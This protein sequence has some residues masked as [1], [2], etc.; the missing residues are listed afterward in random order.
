MRVDQK[1]ITEKRD[2]VQLRKIYT[3][4]QEM[5]IHSEVC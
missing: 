5:Y 4:D 1:K 2:E 3:D